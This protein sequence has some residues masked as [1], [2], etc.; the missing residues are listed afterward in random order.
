MLESV[1]R[2]DLS[3]ES[4]GLCAA[5][6]GTVHPFT[7]ACPSGALA[8]CTPALK[9]MVF[10][11]SAGIRRLGRLS[12]GHRDRHS[13]HSCDAIGH[14]Q[15][16]SPFLR[17]LRAREDLVNSHQAIFTP[18][19]ERGWELPRQTLPI[20]LATGKISGAVEPARN[21]QRRLTKTHAPTLFPLIRAIGKLPP[22]WPWPYE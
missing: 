7:A 17:I 3:Q 11:W 18:V 15:T 4:T 22:T 2:K 16:F 13:E 12:S 14:S 1:I 8:V 21:K 20:A 5:G 9:A 10:A 6:V 19:K